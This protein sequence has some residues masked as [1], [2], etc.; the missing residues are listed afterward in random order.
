MKTK[1]MLK[2]SDEIWDDF[3]KLCSKD[4]S[5]NEAVIGLINEYVRKNK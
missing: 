5:M 3:K 1:L 4:K 2:C